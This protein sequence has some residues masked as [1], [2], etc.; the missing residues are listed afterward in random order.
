MRHGLHPHQRFDRQRSTTSVA[1]AAWEDSDARS[2]P[3][4]GLALKEA[5]NCPGRPS[6]AA[7]RG[8]VPIVPEARGA[9]ARRGAP[10]LV[11]AFEDAPWGCAVEVG[12]GVLAELGVV[13]DDGDLHPVG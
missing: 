6:P 10:P 9:L 4:C 5:S 13:H 12:W 3:Q 8:A 11:I 1:D 7:A 2:G